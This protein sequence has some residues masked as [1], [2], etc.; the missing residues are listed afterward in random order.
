MASQARIEFDVV[1]TKAVDIAAR[2][3]EVLVRVEL[4]GGDLVDLQL[5]PHA[6]ARFEELLAAAARSRPPAPAIQ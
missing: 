3:G 5:S 1:D 2:D 4:V 6:W